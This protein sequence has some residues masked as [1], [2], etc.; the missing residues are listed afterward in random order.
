MSIQKIDSIQRH[1]HSKDKIN[2]KA[3]SFKRYKLSA[4]SP[5]PPPTHVFGGDRET[6]DGQVNGQ[7][8]RIN[9]KTHSFKR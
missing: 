1:V 2:H 7:T 3:H 9:L 4:S 8:D 5:Y 6:R